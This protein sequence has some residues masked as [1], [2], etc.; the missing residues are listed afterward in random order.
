MR[1]AADA[2]KLQQPDLFKPQTEFTLR[3]SPLLIALV[4]AVGLPSCSSQQW[5][6]MGQEWQKD[7]CNKLIDMQERNRCM[8][9]TKTS[10]EDYQRQS[11][12]VKGTK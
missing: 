9:S 1:A 5:Y 2:L 12:A 6:G 8:N 4:A 11:E 10:Y 7:K 3:I